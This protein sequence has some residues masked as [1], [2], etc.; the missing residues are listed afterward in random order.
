VVLQESGEKV[1]DTL[2][3]RSGITI[4]QDFSSS[5]YFSAWAA[6]EHIS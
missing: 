1:V 5:L 3:D 6:A 2:N 4:T